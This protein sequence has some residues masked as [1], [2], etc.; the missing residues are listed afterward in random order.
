MITKKLFLSFAMLAAMYFQVQASDSISPAKKYLPEIHATLRARYEV[1]T[2]DGSGR[3]Q[4]RNARV[5]LKGNIAD[6]LGYYLRADFCDKGKFKMLDAYAIFSP[7]KSLKIMA[8]QMRVPLSVDGSRSVDNYWFVNR[9]LPGK[10][11]WTSRKVGLKARYLFNIHSIPVFI[12]GGAF[13]S[14]STSDQSAWSKTYTYGIIGAATVGDWTP[15]IGF[16]SNEL[17]ATRVNLWDASLTWKSGMWEAEAEALCKI[18]SSDAAR[19]VK[20]LNLMGRRF[21]TVKSR[22]IN[23]VSLDCRFDCTSD[24]CDGARDEDGRLVVTQTSRKRITAG[25]TLA[26]LR[27]PVKAHLRLNYE[28]YFHSDAHVYSTADSNKFSIELMLHF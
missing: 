7:S 28:Q 2:A 21:F 25:T 9:S 27:G 24:N 3:Y 20:A 8:G 14:A 13:S 15:E 6:F 18:Y 16:Q 23:R 4:I 11:M 10:D 26:Y 22:Y 12:E 19:S 17:G 1:S 5:N